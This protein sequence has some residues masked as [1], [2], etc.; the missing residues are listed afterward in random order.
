MGESEPFEGR[1]H[2]GA[3]LTVRATARGE[4]VTKARLCFLTGKSRKQIERWII[5]GCP[6]VEAPKDKGGEWKLSTAQVFD[7]L[8]G[9][10][11]ADDEK[12][13]LNDERARLA[14]EQAD[15]QALRNARLRAELLPA[16]EVE[17]AWQSAIG[18]CRALLLG[19]PTSTAGQI[20]LLAS[21]HADATEAERAIR[22]LLVKL[23]DGA[24]NELANTSFDDDEA[25]GAG[26]SLLAA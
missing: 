7:W 16:D 11:D 26:D 25:D 14:R 9:R 20:V 23:I 10:S 2:H 4:I 15:N 18:R 3:L 13:D 24:L 1:S 5:E 19:I 12:P 17:S 8:E 22:E 21:K 6:V